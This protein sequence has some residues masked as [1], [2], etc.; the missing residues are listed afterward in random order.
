M[1]PAVPTA[2]P[3]QDEPVDTARNWADG[4]SPIKGILDHP[5]PPPTARC[6]AE[7]QCVESI[8]SG[9]QLQEESS[10]FAIRSDELSQAIAKA[11]GCEPEHVEQTW[12]MIVGSPRTHLVVALLDGQLAVLR[13][14]QDGRSFVTVELT[15]SFHSPPRC[16]TRAAATVDLFH[17]GEG[18]LLLAS[19]GATGSGLG[20]TIVAIYRVDARRLTCIFEEE[21]SF[22]MCLDFDDENAIEKRSTTTRWARG[23][24]SA[25]H[26]R[27]L[28]IATHTLGEFRSRRAVEYEWDGMR[29]SPANPAQDAVAAKE[30]QVRVEDEQA[31]LRQRAGQGLS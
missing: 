7:F 2:A 8:E 1:Q 9:S 4:A 23:Y 30:E 17:D 25:V 28:S 21:I 26:P 12:S 14:A 29:F 22:N 6:N 31:R 11:V 24:G 27:I 13:V 18:Q 3:E 20:Q 15:P 19:D 16:D 5:L 10:R